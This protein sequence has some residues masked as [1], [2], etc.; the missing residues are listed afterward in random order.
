MLASDDIYLS[1]TTGAYPAI[2]QIT[3]TEASHIPSMWR[4]LYTAIERCNVLLENL[5]KVTD[6]EEGNRGIIR[7]EA[8]FLRAYCHFLLV[9]HWGAVPLKLKPTAGPTDVNAVRTPVAE[10]YAQILTDM[11]E[12]EG[13]VPNTASA[14]YGGAGYPAKTTIQGILARVCLTMAGE[15]LKDV[16]KYEDVK[17][18]SQKVISSGEHS[19]N[20]D[21]TQIFINLAAGVFDKKEVMWEID[22]NDIPGASEHGYIGYLNG[23]AGAASSFA[24]TAGQHRIT[25]ILFNAYGGT[26]A[27]TND[28]RRDWNCSAFYYRNSTTT[29]AEIDKVYFATTDIYSRYDAKWRSQYTPAPRLVN[30]SPINFPVLR[31]SDV[32]LMR[33]EAENYLN[34]G[35]NALAYSLVDQVRARA[36]G[37]L[38]AGATNPAEADLPQIYDVTTFLKEIQDERLREFP[39][40]ALRRHDLVRWG[41]YV[42]AIRALGADVNDPSQPAVGTNGKPQMI[43]LSSLVSNRDVLWPIPAVELTYNPKMTQNPGW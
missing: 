35:P 4:D 32:L 5:P 37:K 43:S 20:P 36:Y 40:E 2:L 18:W 22:F 30:R 6:I 3:A 25:R 26:P 12:A 1:F 23:I 21:Y 39:S 19:L 31:Y 10:V 27:S 29:G 9:D 13:L 34:N 28:T 42:S 7:G 15:P 11:T 33:A 16:T 41:I 24:P 38:K 8:L 14:L 17:T